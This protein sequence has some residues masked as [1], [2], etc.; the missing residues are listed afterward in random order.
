MEAELRLP[1]AVI[2]RVINERLEKH[3]LNPK[4]QSA[5]QKAVMLAATV[6]LNYI[7][8]MANEVAKDHKR[9]V[10]NTTDVVTALK[11]TDFDDIA[12]LLEAD[13]IPQLAVAAK[14]KKGKGGATESSRED[15]EEQETEETEAMD[16]VGETEICEPRSRGNADEQQDRTAMVLDGKEAFEESSAM[17]SV[18]APDPLPTN[19]KTKPT[20]NHAPGEFDEIVPVFD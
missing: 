8:G 19:P 17:H 6:F 9:V 13:V 7:S 12:E 1:A 4:V 18:V 3:G 2:R 10:V 16:V 20:S 11:E 15:E 14:Q 5:G